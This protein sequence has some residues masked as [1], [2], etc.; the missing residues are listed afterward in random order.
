MIED[1]HTSD[2][3]AAS[4]DSIVRAAARFGLTPADLI[5]V[6]GD[7]EPEPLQPDEAENAI[8]RRI[9][10]VDVEES[11]ATLY[12]T[13][14]DG[15]YLTYAARIDEDGVILLDR[16]CQAEPSYHDY[17]VFDEL[18]GES[19]P[20]PEARRPAPG[21][22]YHPAAWQGAVGRIVAH[23]GWYEEGMQA[24][25]HFEEG[26]YLTVAARAEGGSAYL[27]GYSSPTE[28]ESPDDYVLFE[29]GDEDETA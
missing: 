29:P 27:L 25:V 15:S 22:L 6:V 23:L 8:G 3:D 9:A 17:W 19:G 10:R 5:G 2:R 21:S 14:E 4:S 18:E 12:L 7:Q 20:P 1:E 26:G 24:F 11:F 16:F 28:P 13:F